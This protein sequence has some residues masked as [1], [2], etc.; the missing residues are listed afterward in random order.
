LKKQIGKILLIVVPIIIAIILLY[1]TYEA[2]QLETKKATVEKLAKQ[3][4]S[5]ADSLARMERFN[6]TYGEELESASENKIKL[7]LDLRGGMYVTL[8]VDVVKLIDESAQ[9][10]TKDEYFE[11]VIEA[12]RQETITSDEPVIDI[13]LEKFEK[14]ARPNGKSLLSYFDVG[15]LRDATE[16]KIIERLKD[17]EESAIDQALEVIRQR[18]D[19]YGVSEPTIQK[20]GSR[21]IMLELPGVSRDED[22]RKLLQTTAR[23]EFNLVKNDQRIVRTFYKIDKLLAEQ[24]KRRKEIE[25]TTTT[26]T[27]LDSTT[28]VKGDS[29]VQKEST[30]SEG[31]TAT[32]DTTMTDSLESSQADTS[33]PYAGL[34]DEEKQERYLEDHPFTTLFV[35]YYNPPG[36]MSQSQQVGYAVD[37]FPEEGDYNFIIYEPTLNR[38]NEI[39]SR[40][41]IKALIPADLKILREAKPDQRILKANNINAYNFYALKAEPELTGDVITNAM[42]TFDPQSNQPMVTMAMNSDGAERWARITGANIKKRIAIVLDDQVYSAPT[43]Q[44][45][46]TGGNSQITGM[47]DAEEAHLLEIV[48]KA[49]ALK[50]PVQIIEE[51]VVGPS[52]GED[53][54][55]SGLTSLA[56]AAGLVILFMLIYYSIGGLIA[57]F[58]VLLNITLIISI[59]A[60]FQGTLTLPGIAGLIL[61]IGMAVDANILIFE[62]IREELRKGRSLRSAVDEGFSK[63]YSAITDSNITTGI[64]AMILYFLGTGPIQGFALT[65]LIGIFGT[66]FTGIMVS[67]AIIELSLS[68]GATKFSFGQPKYV[69]S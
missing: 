24:S 31:D 15:D 65:L 22:I 27:L 25:D 21:R 13:F 30:L 49:G 7:G 68:K 16:E 12:T 26:K 4:T 50:A 6:N 9:R 59:L 46:I 34:S 42:A 57:D 36:E 5:S 41:E 23:L 37:E 67:R 33:D 44:N 40:P 28:A 56:I 1:P 20:Q 52:L 10:E 14:I 53:S 47:E 63:A 35:T 29:T 17:N 32:K 58:A 43:V 61:T 11:Q 60:A 19:K 2:S 66:L 55:R 3:D 62:R 64:T 8:E 54:I 48:L 51:R 45:K 38:F 39:L 69:E 18:I